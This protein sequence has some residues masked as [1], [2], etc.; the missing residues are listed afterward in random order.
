MKEDNE[1]LKIL[2]QLQ[3]NE[4]TEYYIYK[5]LAKVA[6]GDN[7]II[8]E[9][10]AEDEKIHYGIWKKHSGKDV[11]PRKLRI[12]LYRF[13]LRIVGLTF[14]LKLME[15]K[16][17]IGQADY[18][19]LIDKLPEAAKILEEE[20][21]HENELIKMIYE[22]KLIYLGSIILGLNDALVEL[23]GALAGMTLILNQTKLIGIAGLVT[24][25]AASLSMMSSEYLS[26][27][28]EEQRN[29]FKASVYTGIAYIL[30]VAYLVFPYFIFFNK[31]TAL[32]LTLFNAIIII[33]LFTYFLSVAKDVNFKKR[34]LEM[35]IISMSVSAFSFG[36]GYFLRVSLNI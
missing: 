33:L 30:T 4:I 15:Q 25:I 24:G 11:S 13:L 23:T 14:T 32:G 9:N 12:L 2:L 5:R 35:L 31:Y 17:E 18:K 27:K 22:E 19:K 8:L 3:R 34:F 1:L 21:K 28:S 26:K 16:E 6:E 29:P 20:N 36:L 10:I 7:K